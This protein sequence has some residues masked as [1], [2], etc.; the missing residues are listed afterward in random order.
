MPI[1]PLDYLEKEYANLGQK[2]P[3]SLRELKGSKASDL[4]MGSTEE[5]THSV[6]D[7]GLGNLADYEDY[8]DLD[9]TNVISQDVNKLRAQE[10]SGAAQGFNAVVGGVASGLATAVE[11]VSYLLDFDNHIKALAGQ[12]TWEKNWL[13]EV[14]GE[15]K[16]GVDDAMPIYRESSDI[17]DWNDPGFYWS[18][19]K[20]VI[21]SAVG[22]GLPGG[23]IAKTTGASLKALRVGKFMDAIKV[24]A[25]G[26]NLLTAGISGGIQNYAEGKIMG[27]ETYENTYNRLIKEGVDEVKAKGLA[28]QA[29]DEMLLNNRA[30][31]L[32]DAFSLYGLARGLEGAQRN[33]LKAPGLRNRFK[34]FGKNIISP[35]A[36]N[37]I[38]QGA[39]EAGEE[40]A[41]N[42][43][44]MEAQYGAE[45]AAKL[46]VSDKPENLLE[47]MYEFATSDQALLEGM[48]GFFGGGPQRILTEVTSGNLKKSNR[49]AYKERYEAQQEAIAE[50]GTFVQ[51]VTS[52]TSKRFQE[53]DKAKAKGDT[54][55]AKSI[56]RV[57]I[58]K[59]VIFNIG[60][61]TLEDFE[62]RAHQILED[63]ASTKEQK[64][65]ASAMLEEVSS[66]EKV[67]NRHSNK[68][69]VD[70]IL[71]NHLEK[72]FTKEIQ[73]NTV[74][75]I[76]E[77]VS[78][79]EETINTAILPKYKPTLKGTLKEGLEMSPFSYD[80]G[81]IMENP[82]D[83][84]VQKKAYAQY[85]RFKKRVEK[86]PA[87][88]ELES[89]Q[90]SLEAIN[91]E[92]DKNQLEFLHL[93]SDEGQ[94]AA[95]KAKQD[96]ATTAQANTDFRKST[97]K[98]EVQS[99]VPVSGKVYESKSGKAWEFV[100]T[101][102]EGD[103]NMKE[104]GAEKGRVVSKET[105]AKNFISDEGTVSLR[106]DAA[107]IK[108]AATESA[109]TESNLNT[110]QVHPKTPLEE[111]VAANPA[112]MPSDVT[113]VE[114]SN[115]D[116]DKDNK[117][118]EDFSSSDPLALAW[119]SASNKEEVAKGKTPTSKKAS[120]FLEDR[121]NT[122][123]GIEVE[124]SLEEGVL[125]EYK[126][127][128]GEEEQL[129]FKAALVNE[130]DIKVD[131]PQ[132]IGAS[133]FMHLPTFNKKKEGYALS[134]GTVRYNIVEEILSS[135]N[136]RIYSTITK[137]GPG[138][139]QKGDP[140]QNIKALLQEEDSSKIILLNRSLDHKLYTGKDE[141]GNLLEDE[142]LGNTFNSEASSGAIYIKVPRA[143]EEAFPMRVQVSTVSPAI[144]EL[145]IDI[146]LGI[147][148]KSVSLKN[149]TLL[150]NSELDL[151]DPQIAALVK[152]MP[153]DA[154]VIDL[155]NTLVYEGEGTA[156]SP[157]ALYRKGNYMRFGGLKNSVAMSALKENT[158]GAR[159][160]LSQWLQDNKIHNISF[161]T[162]NNKAYKDYLFDNGVLTGNSEGNSKG[163]V[164]SQPTITISGKYHNTPQKEKGKVDKMPV[165]KEIIEQPTTQSE[166]T[167]TALGI[168]A[169]EMKAAIAAQAKSQKPEKEKEKVEKKVQKQKKDLDYKVSVTA[170][171]V[172]R[173]FQAIKEGE[174]GKK[175]TPKMETDFY[176][177]YKDMEIYLGEAEALE[178]A[179]LHLI[180]QL[181]NCK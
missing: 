145:I 29:A 90:G 179:K 49:Q 41:Q 27:I 47:R 122:L 172:D 92:L 112:T 120:D 9:N 128:Q 160:E 95:I 56:E 130:G 105:F 76:Q 101:T 151:T 119:L 102:P 144:S 137:K 148:D 162:L 53:R 73:E 43:I 100:G 64:E 115:E 118:K 59:S 149:K 21:D 139:I 84:K 61:G 57:E 52:N 65:T 33:I 14:M 117:T 54:K 39:K 107:T 177:Q 17:F 106:E 69:N 32:T 142:E 12:D 46:D 22:F 93:I 66:L 178:I 82:Y 87:I 157:Y 75:K 48:M 135:P 141:D 70:N 113:K 150:I 108:N 169:E 7:L 28:G 85:E 79:L 38:L 8:L 36:D 74:E 86:E 55:T 63:E 180:T 167:P 175:M 109:K 58:G 166:D 16:E 15:F 72:T 20:G 96:R 104:V 45:K 25:K 176:N 146:Y 153:E 37:L 114:P 23:A 156:T 159:Q 129:A 143:N 147:W 11:D 164:F 60:M 77:T 78:E 3:S 4:T 6:A 98:V 42:A 13:A 136:G 94:E 121:D 161:G 124:I 89:L 10:Q 19:L 165:P 34:D 171:Q 31:I 62:S 50:N 111:V 168:T 163:V 97:E 24:G 154:T 174:L 18:S 181:E 67:Y 2:P 110:N 134:M 88:K 126:S 103:Y 99:T 173:V 26:E 5:R 91:E 123:V 116:A 83:P 132:E 170:G 125:E 1:D 152:T 133:L 140:N 71:F 40:M 131:L 81:S 138:S 158:N 155:L 127:I 68:A 44:Q 51:D 30:M 35:N 80:I